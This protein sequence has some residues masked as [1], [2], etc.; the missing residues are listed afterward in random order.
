[1][2]ERRVDRSARHGIATMADTA[3]KKA[4]RAVGTALGGR[5]IPVTGIDREGEDVDTPLFCV[6]VKRRLMFP[7]WLDAWLS[8]ICVRAKS[9]GKIGLLVLVTP[10]QRKA[11]AMVVMRMADF[12]DLCGTLAPHAPDQ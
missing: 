7:A 2:N 12:T 4:E 9:H 10:G 3:W 11:N 5:R 1:M 6:Q 8:G